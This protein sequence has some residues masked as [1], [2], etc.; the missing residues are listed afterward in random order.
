MV[1]MKKYLLSLFGGNMALRYPNRGKADKA[2]LPEAEAGF[3]M[4]AGRQTEASEHLARR[5]VDTVVYG[6]MAA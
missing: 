2:A 1:S 4:H 6:R 3:I 5:P